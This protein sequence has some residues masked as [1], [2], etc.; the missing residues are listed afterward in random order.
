[1]DRHLHD[2]QEELSARAAPRLV[3]RILALGLAASAVLGGCASQP[4]GS[5]VVLDP[6]K[7]RTDM[8]TLVDISDILE[9]SQRMVE[10]MRRSPTL[11]EALRAGRPVQIAIDPRQIKNLT[12]MTNFSKA[13]F[14][15]QLVATLNKVAGDDFRFL[16]RE[17]V[18]AERARQLSGAAATA[19]IDP[20]PAGADLVLSGRILEKLDREAA[21][22]G[23]VQETR[24]VQF[25]FKLVRVKDAV[26]LWTDS[27]FRVK[28]QVI[29][30]VYS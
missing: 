8:G 6:T 22:G 13:L 4:E 28:Q 11:D 5:D 24:A 2:P 29:G 10:S 15:N 21:A 18:E 26:T 7:T 16:D 27:A 25:S 9:V 1:V 30:S 20:A 3:R 14:V 12:S 23:A 17:A 19:G